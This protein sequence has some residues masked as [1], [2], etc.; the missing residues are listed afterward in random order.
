RSRRT[1]AVAASEQST[2]STRQ[3]NDEER[4]GD[5]V[6]RSNVGASIRRSARQRR[7]RERQNQ[8]SFVTQIEAMRT[9]RRARRSERLR[10]FLRQQGQGEEPSTPTTTG[11]E[12]SNNADD[13]LETRLSIIEEAGV[14]STPPPS[15]TREQIKQQLIC[16]IDY[17]ASHRVTLPLLHPPPN[18]FH[19]TSGQ[20]EASN[21][22]TGPEVLPW[23]GPYIDWLSITQPRASPYV[24][25]LGDRLVY[26]ARGHKEYLSRAWQD[27]SVPDIDEVNAEGGQLSSRRLPLPWEV[28][29]GLPGYLCCRVSEMAVHFMRITNESSSRRVH[30]GASSSSTRRHRQAPATVT[31]RLRRSPIR[32][33]PLQ[34][35]DSGDTTADSFVRLVSLR[36]A[37]DDDQ[38]YTSLG[39]VGSQESSTP[40]EVFVRYHDVDGVLDFLILRSVFDEAITR[41]WIAGDVFI[42][43]VDDIWWRGRVLQDSSSLSDSTSSAFDPWL[44]VRVRW[45]ENWETGSTDEPLL[46]SSFSG[47]LVETVEEWDRARTDANV[48]TYSDRLSPWDMHPWDARLPISDGPTSTLSASYMHSAEVRIP[49]H[50]LTRLFGSRGAQSLVASNPGPST[51]T[52]QPPTF[53]DVIEQMKVVL[54]KLMSLNAASAFNWPVDLAAFPNYIVVNPHLV[55]LL[56]IRHRLENLFYRQSDAI[57]FDIEQIYAN[58][59][60]YNE[61]QS[62]I[63]HQAQLITSLALQAMS[64]PSLTWEKLLEYYIAAVRLNPQLDPTIDVSQN[65]SSSTVPAMEDLEVGLGSDSPRSPTLKRLRPLD[66]PISVSSP[67]RDSL[68]DVEPRRSGESYCL[69]SLALPPPLQPP[70][71]D[72]DDNDNADDSLNWRKV[73]EKLLD[74]LLRHRRSLFFREPVNVDQYTNYAE[75]I[76]NPMDLASVQSRLRPHPR[77]A[78]ANLYTSPRQFLQDLELIVSNSLLFNSNVDAQ[79][80]SDTRWLS[81]WITKVA[82]RRL[83]LFLGN[84]SPPAGPST[85]PSV[86]ADVRRRRMRRLRHPSRAPSSYVPRFSRSLRSSSE[87]V[88]SRP[89][90]PH[91]WEH[92]ARRTS[93]GEA[94]QP[95]RRT[96]RAQASGLV[97]SSGDSA[98][99]LPNY[100]TSALPTRTSSLASRRPRRKR[101]LR[102]SAREGQRN[103]GAVGGPRRSTRRRSHHQQ[104]T[105]RPRRS[106]ASAVRHYFENEM[107]NESDQDEENEEQ[108]SS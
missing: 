100:A 2:S 25:Q 106:A 42:C 96:L 93:G 71:S 8:L 29:P 102:L 101:I 35:E 22:S 11:P 82:T 53:G 68:V 9:L 92:G 50:R 7:R 88:R 15:N 74:E 104:T 26:I 81:R 46:P 38:P 47:D 57:L 60:R 56:F 36:L 77:Q 37:V 64:S 73:C 31:G 107:V 54:D 16:S 32:A 78:N 51:S 99:T 61:P 18:G 19:G 59:V 63:V 5:R 24:P 52:A 90:E 103:A 14:P 1:H 91:G 69:R 45:L 39:G 89:A 75:I 97:V 4:T 10:R 17:V 41:N 84:E 33:P 94:P 72:D 79:V 76:E 108:Y 23:S 49:V 80:Y 48:V 21:V 34:T 87:A 27:G 55:D 98:A 105:S 83:A 20:T 28:N 62:L 13:D 44:S 85:Q 67:K 3:E 58:A 86:G 30:T 65:S 70:V 66:L 43:P 6:L 40:R 95:G 12:E